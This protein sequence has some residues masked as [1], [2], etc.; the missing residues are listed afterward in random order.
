M[1]SNTITERALELIANNPTIDIIKAVKE[2]ILEENKIICELYENRTER[3]KNL[4]SLMYQKVYN[5]IIKYGNN[6][7]TKKG[8]KHQ[9][10]LYST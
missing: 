7:K 1:L 2:A 8:K 5:K 6:T 9:G 3:A 10:S 4:N